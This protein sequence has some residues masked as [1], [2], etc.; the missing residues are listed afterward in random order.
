MAK[1]AESAELNAPT[2]QRV[3]SR[4]GA[5]TGAL[6]GGIYGANEGYNRNG[7]PGALVGG[8]AG[9]AIPEGMASPTGKMILARMLNSGAKKVLPKV[10][11][12]SG[13]QLDR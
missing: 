9:V 2:T 7:L 13:L 4:F 10:F 12:G 1:R 5:H 3:L 11:V 6:A 8:L